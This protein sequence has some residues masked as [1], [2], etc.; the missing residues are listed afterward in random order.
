MHSLGALP[1]A[2]RRPAPPGPRGHLG[3]PEPASSAPGPGRP[4][5]PWPVPR[6]RGRR[7]P[8]RFQKGWARDDRLLAQRPRPTEARGARHW[9]RGYLGRLEGG[10]ADTRRSGVPPVRRR[11]PTGQGSPDPGP[12]RAHLGP[13]ARLGGV[14]FS[15]ST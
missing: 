5:A 15:A 3:L 10:A 2:P 8:R 9:G 14:P 6:P 4:A 12:A 11:E 1:P 7:R 13:R